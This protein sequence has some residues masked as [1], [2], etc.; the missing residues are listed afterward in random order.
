MN[1]IVYPI[2]EED[3]INNKKVSDF[4]QEIYTFEQMLYIYHN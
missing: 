1:L 4:L 3:L 2:N